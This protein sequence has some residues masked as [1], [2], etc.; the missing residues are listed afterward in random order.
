MSQLSNNELQSIDTRA[1]EIGREVFANLPDERP[2]VFDRRWWDD[3]LMNWSMSD[4]LLKVELFRFVDVLPM[5]DT[6]E[7][8][9]GHLHEYLSEVKDRLPAPMRVALGVARRTPG[10]RAAVAKAARLAAMD[11]A[12]RFIA[13]TNTKE[14]IQSAKKQRSLR[15]GFTLDIL[16]EAVT[17][18]READGYEQIDYDAAE[19][20]CLEHKPKMI[21][22]GYSAYPREIDFPRFRAIADKVGALL[23]A[24]IAHIAGL[25]AGG[26]HPSPF[27]YAHIVTTTTHKTLRGP[28][29]GLILT[30]DEEIA[31]KIDRAVFPG[32]QGGPLMHVIAAKAVAFHEALQ[33][34]FKHYATQIVANAKALAEAL[35]KRGHRLVSGGTDNHLMLLDLRERNADLTGADAETWLEAAGIIVNKNGI[36]NDP[37]PPKLC[38]GLRIGTPATT[39][40]GLKE[41]Q[42]QQ[43][44]EWIDRVLASGGDTAVAKQVRGEVEALCAQFPMPH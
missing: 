38:S 9:T 37:R 11:F 41:P 40:R 31:K 22:C 4:E 15:R 1:K 34:S 13:G 30:S 23:M 3:H 5:L 17:S 29:G 14:V 6:S 8:V 24:D 10:V 44:A 39:T 19:Q 26:M 32:M 7:A 12:R 42:M 2:G 16:G 43:L 36:P 20:L 25:V 27:P 18:D 28:R 21:L 35:M 33:P